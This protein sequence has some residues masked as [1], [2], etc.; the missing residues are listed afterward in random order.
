MS[1][2][3]CPCGNII[4]DH[5]SGL[6]YKASLLKDYLSENFWDW[7]VQEIQSYVT[8]AECGGIREWLLGRGYGEEYIAL[9]LDHGN[10]LHDHIQ[11]KYLYL[12]RDVYECSVCGRIHVE[13]TEDNRFFAYVPAS[14]NKNG[15]LSE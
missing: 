8:A 2:L 6:P 11:S 12:K 5:T 15:V 3:G 10:V 7:L 1:K 4:R 9:Q 13:T 14:E